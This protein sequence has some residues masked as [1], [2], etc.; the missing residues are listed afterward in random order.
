MRSCLTLC[1]GSCLCLMLA[2]GCAESGGGTAGMGGDAGSGGVGGEGG[3]GGIIECPL[4]GM[5]GIGGTD[6]PLCNEGMAQTK[7]VGVGCTNNVTIAQTP[8]PYDL[9]IQVTSPI[10]GGCSF[11]AE[12]DGVGFFP[13][14][15]LDTAQSVI[16]PGLRVAELKD[17]AATVQV[18]SG[19]TGD[20]V[21]LGIDLDTLV[22]G[23]TR[24]CN[25]PADQECSDDADCS[26]G[27][28]RP[29]VNLQELP[30]LEG[31]P[32]SEGGC[33]VGA[34]PV[35]AGALPDCD[36]SAC[37][38]LDVDAGTCTEGQAGTSECAKENQCRTNGFCIS[39]PLTVELAAV[40][41]SYTARA[42]GGQVLWGWADKNVP[43]LTLCPADSPKCPSSFPQF[44]DGCYQIPVAVATADPEPIGIRLGAG[45]LDVAIQCA[46]A[47][48]GGECTDAGGTGTRVGCLC[49]DLTDVDGEC[50]S[51]SC[52]SGETCVG[53][54]QDNDIV[55]PSP[56]SSL[57]SCPIN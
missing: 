27:V 53:V 34:C 32:N 54:G 3:T 48:D 20:D 40:T 21:V 2:L 6:Y 4:D 10:V 1:L 25:F 22:P 56:D 8:F 24:L 30:V 7:T 45:R 38:A 18:R 19:A 17:F 42:P 12:L 57:V 44:V 46:M 11:E 35:V 47:E 29:P 13:E 39:G 49:D 43:D 26:G 36:C 28:C 55:C 14:F 23:P 31:T 50:P 37:L 5:G 41:G 33:D 51:S 9:S 15:F 16:C 52:A